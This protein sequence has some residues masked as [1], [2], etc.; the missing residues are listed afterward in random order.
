MTAP[1]PAPGQVT[2]AKRATAVPGG[3]RAVRSGWIRWPVWCLT[4]VVLPLVLLASIA[5]GVLYVRLLNGPISLKLIAQPIARAI[6]AE[7]PGFQATI[8]DASVLMTEGRG[9]EFRL[10]NVGLLDARGETVARAPDAAVVLSVPALWSGRIAPA[11]VVLIEPS[12]VLQHSAERGLYLSFNEAPTPSPLRPGSEEPRSST[13]HKPEAEVGAA[14]AAVLS[15]GSQSTGSASYIKGIGLRN[16][17][18]LIDSGGS[19]ASM[20]IREADIGM[21]R[22][23][24]GS[25]LGISLSVDTQHAP[26]QLTL[27]ANRDDTT[28]ITNVDAKFADLIPR[29]AASSFPML[30]PL[31]VLDL[32]M[33]GSA[34]LSLSRQGELTNAVADIELASGYVAPG[35]RGN[36]RLRIDGGRIAAKYDPASRLLAFSTSRISSGTSW[37]SFKGHVSIGAGHGAPWQLELASTEGQLAAPEFDIAPRPLEAFRVR[38]RLDPSSGVFDL[39]EAVLK[40]S[41]GE[42]S[43]SGHVP[44]RGAA[45]RLQLKGRISPMSVDELKLLWPSVVAPAARDWSGRRVQQGRLTSGTFSIEDSR[46]PADPTKVSVSIE[47]TAVRIQ[48][49]PGFAPVEAQ[50]VL[51]R[52][53]DNALEVAAP[54]AVIH[55]TPQRRLPIRGVRMVSSDVTA[56]NAVGDLTF[57]AQ[58]ALAAAL[59]LAEQ[60]AARNGRSLALPG[61]G[62]DGRVDAQVRIVVPLGDDLTANDTR[63]DIKGRI[64]EGRARGVIGSWDINGATLAVELTDQQLEAKG[65]LLVAGVS[66]KLTL[67][68]IFAAPDGEQPPILLTATLDTADRAQLGLDVNEFVVGEMPIEVLVTP[69]PQAEPQV[70][71]RA[72]LTN[73]E[74]VL[75]PLAWRKAPGRPAQL[76]FEVV[77]PNR[78]RTE[79]QGFRIVGE[80]ISLSGNLVLDGRNKLREFAFSELI[81]HVVSRLQ[82]AGTLRNDNVWDVTGRGST[83]DG[84]DFFKS[85]F[86]LTQVR[87]KPLPPRKDQSGL[88][89]KVDIDNVLGHHDVSLRTLKL[90][91]SNRAGRTVSM[92]ARGVVEGTGRQGSSPLE[93]TISQAGREPRRL[94]ARSDDAGQV[95][96]MIGFFPNMAGGSMNLDVNLDGSGAAE[97]TGRLYVTSFAILGDP[98]DSPVGADSRPSQRGQRRAERSRLDFDSM[99]AQFELGHGQVVIREA[100]LRGQVLGVVM[101]GKADFRQQ[102]V[103][104]GGTY[105]PLQGLNSAIGQFPLLGVILAGPRGE[106]VI[107]MTFAIQGPMGRP[108]VTI[109]PISAVPG[110][111]LVRD[112]MQMTNPNPRITPRDAP[113]QPTPAAKAAP[114]ARSSSSPATAPAKAGTPTRAAPPR[115]ETD[116]GWSSSTVKS[117]APKA[118]PRTN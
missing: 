28:G 18:L 61:E 80:D 85:L 52:Y 73:A 116:G 59:D 64:S 45:T 90:H 71:V 32:P 17:T 101:K 30:E 93:V 98:V 84:R 113:P 11:R 38:G 12:L 87:S 114:P 115:V 89:L 95:F 56:P 21:D 109:N 6:A 43:M 55:T 24:N 42:V 35:W 19:R 82:L 48:P 31:S 39:A 112:L 7:L 2:R 103:D 77:R 76:Q 8:E 5:M 25:V 4:R 99:N 60:Q 51:V 44:P 10:R 110:T 3:R 22:R 50:R 102:L 67:R 36:G 79:L 47:G 81:L 83:L 78:Q 62:L 27:V 111:A 34:S 37:G 26:W 14:L 1:R 100:D 69:R 75:E 86:S 16:A 15:Q 63:L 66:T 13:T 46:Q 20:R 57:R 91:L 58:G 9:L 72:N 97:K 40:T 88:E 33:H 41:G 96:R 94:L 49:K 108:Q 29:I 104:L 107:G 74:L 23:R 106:G 54:E 65:D 105:V 53:D 117:T 68:R 92:H 70:Q 118:A